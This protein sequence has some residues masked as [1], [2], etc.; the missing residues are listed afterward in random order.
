MGLCGYKVHH[1]SDLVVLF[2]LGAGLFASRARA[3][4][5][6]DE[7]AHRRD[8]S[9][10]GC[11]LDG[12]WM[13]IVGDAASRAHGE[14]G[15]KDYVSDLRDLRFAHR[16]RVSNGE[17][18]GSGRFDWIGCG[19]A[20]GILGEFVDAAFGYVPVGSGGIGRRN[21]RNGGCDRRDA[22]RESSWLRAAMD[23]ELHGA[24]FD[25]GSGIF[26]W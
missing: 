2:V 14:R 21:R 7:F 20:P 4:A 3:F 12:W 10:F 5:F 6:A 23:G 18:V 15:A 19:G 26:D 25:G 1:R 17:F 22:D 24:V 8:L 16:V 11:R 9:D 13:G